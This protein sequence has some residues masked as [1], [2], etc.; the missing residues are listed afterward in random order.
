M[1]TAA[2]ACLTPQPLFRPTAEAA[3]ECDR[4]GILAISAKTEV[5]RQKINRNHFDWQLPLLIPL[6]SFYELL[7]LA[8]TKCRLP[9]N[10]LTQE[11]QMTG[12]GQSTISFEMS[13]IRSHFSSSKNSPCSRSAGKASAFVVVHRIG[14]L[15]TSR[16]TKGFSLLMN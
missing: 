14:R 11:E 5:T 2:G 1:A 9:E 16:T 15:L 13:R 6:S 12:S 4:S 3:A 10:S 8:S 7:S